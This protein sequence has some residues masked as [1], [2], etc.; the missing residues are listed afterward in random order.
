MVERVLMV[1]DSEMIESYLRLGAFGSY[2]EWDSSFRQIDTTGFGEFTRAEFFYVVPPVP[3]PS[4]I[5]LTL[6]GVAMCA[7]RRKKT[8]R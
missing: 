1:C 6:I 4:T 8:N 7:V 5:G 2:P 3:E